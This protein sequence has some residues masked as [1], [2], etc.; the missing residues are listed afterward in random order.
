MLERSRRLAHV[1]TALLVVAVVGAPGAAAADPRPRQ[2]E[3]WFSAWGVDDLMWPISKGKGVTVG[4]IDSGV[5][6]D[7]PDLRGVVLPGLDAENWGTD[8]RRDLNRFDKAG[9]GTAMASAIA[10]QGRGTGMVGVAPEA[11]ILPVLAQSVPAYIKGIHYVVD[12]GATV[13]NLSQAV[14]IP[15]PPD[16]QEAVSYALERDAV[17]AGNEGLEGNPSNTPANCKGVLAV[18]AVDARLRPWE[19]TQRQD[20]VTVAAPGVHTIALGRDGRLW[21]G[22]GTSDATA[23]T[24]GVIALVR[25]RFPQMTNRELVRQ[26]IASAKD[27]WVKGRDDRTGYGVIRPYR[28]LARTAPK[29]TANPVFEDYDRWA[30]RHQPTPRPKAS[31]GPDDAVSTSTIIGFLTI[32]LLWVLVSTI[33]VILARRKTGQSGR[34]PGPPPLGPG[35]GTGAGIPP[36][37]GSPPQPLQPSG[38]EP[39]GQPPGG[40]HQ[41][42]PLHGPLPDDGPAP[43][44]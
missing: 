2:G 27:V 21:G 25:A 41:P 39:S 13:V 31:P 12:H 7:L 5:E 29:A 42:H 17:G 6:A 44:G 23:L 9:H 8:G 3:W 16:L 37:F 33:V 32:A 1:A 14:P 40:P 36:G 20:Y 30:E 38:G 11:K 43:P 4:L 22:S 15:C 34:P 10:G 19:K 26:L 24:S 35:L 28:L 18:G